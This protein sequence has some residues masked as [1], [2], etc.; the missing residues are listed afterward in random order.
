[1]KRYFQMDVDGPSAEIAIYGD[2]TS[3]PFL[4]SD[5]S[6]YNLSQRLSELKDVSEITV[7]INSYGGEVA[8]GIAIYNALK[9]HPARVTTVCDGFAC[10]IASVIFMA[11]DERVMNEASLLMIHN[12]WSCAAGDAEGHRKEADDLD[13]VT[14]LSKSI[15]LAATDLTEDELAEWMDAETFVSA[16]VALDRGFATEIRR[17]DPARASQSALGTLAGRLLEM[18]PALSVRP[19]TAHAAEKARDALVDGPEETGRDDPPGEDEPGEPA[20]ERDES[21]DRIRMAG[22]FMALFS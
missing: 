5:V 4:E 11:G 14:D 8:E 9:N 12:A 22:A 18:A 10:S 16:Q 21:L 13:V 6:S 2:I 1:M 17:V 15:Y 19:E 20:Q 3:W 7:R